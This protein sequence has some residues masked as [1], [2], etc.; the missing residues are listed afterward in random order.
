MGGSPRLW[1]DPFQWRPR[2]YNKRADA[3]C[4]LVL[5]T[6]SEIQY[7]SEDCADI[8]THTEHLLTYSDGACRGD[9]RSSYGWVIYAVIE[10]DG[11]REHLTLA[12]QGRLLDTNAS[13]FVTEALALEAAT[14]MVHDIICK[15]L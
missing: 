12:L 1:R 11:R 5:D 6:G 7:I 13:S 9:G 2:C 14:A 4:N 8:L 3:L 10:Q 15:Y